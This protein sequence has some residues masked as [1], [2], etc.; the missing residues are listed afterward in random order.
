MWKSSLIE[1]WAEDLEGFNVI[2]LNDKTINGGPGSGNFG[3]AGRIGE[4]G[5]SAPSGSVS[6][7]RGAAIGVG[8]LVE[9]KDSDGNWHTG[10]ITNFSKKK[11]TVK[12]KKWD[13]SEEE[14]SVRVMEITDDKG[15][16]HEIPMWS[17]N[18]KKIR[19][20]DA[21]TDTPA[22]RR[23][24]KQKEALE[25]VFGM[26]NCSPTN[27]KYFLNNMSEHTAEALRDE[28]SKAGEYGVDLSEFTLGK[29]NGTRTEARVFWEKYSSRTGN[30]KLQLEL[31]TRLVADGDGFIAK[32]KYNHE[33]NWHTADDLAGIIRHELGHM[34]AYQIAKDSGIDMWDAFGYR[35][36]SEWKYQAVCRKIIKQA[37]GNKGYT[38]STETKKGDISEY[39]GKNVKEAIAEA[40]SNPNFSDFTKKVANVMT[41]KNFKVTL[42][43]VDGKVINE[44][45]KETPSNSLC[46]GYP[47]SKEDWEILEGIRKEPKEEFLEIPSEK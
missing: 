38:K 2:S 17:P 5:G 23:T 36:F 10:T 33:R 14:M 26:I 44:L 4:V 9:G 11:T 35:T 18:V 1:R 41:D 29:F 24:K 13:N 7:S 46:S 31:S 30:S 34:R 19:R 8:D 16:V 21:P 6:A 12:Y 3:H 37:V 22:E 28:L 39:G 43:E 20:A 32:Q 47:M 45:N 27:Q 25:E 15:K 42:N 40:F